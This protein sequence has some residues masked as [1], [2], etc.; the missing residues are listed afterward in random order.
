MLLQPQPSFQWWT[1]LSGDIVVQSSYRPLRKFVRRHFEWLEKRRTSGKLSWCWEKS[2]FKPAIACIGFQAW[3]GALMPF[4]WESSFS[5]GFVRWLVQ[6]V[7]PV[8]DQINP[9]MHW[10]LFKNCRGSLIADFLGERFYL[11][12]HRCTNVTLNSVHSHFLDAPSHLY[13]R[14]CPSVGP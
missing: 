5:T 14:S 1:L 9:K 12:S 8:D 2:R 3:D 13:K 7:A 11:F 6:M 10:F 4:H